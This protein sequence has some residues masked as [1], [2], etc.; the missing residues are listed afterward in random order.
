[1]ESKEMRGG[2]QFG[3]HTAGT[4]EATVTKTNRGRLSLSNW[5]QARHLCRVKISRIAAEGREYVVGFEYAEYAHRAGYVPGEMP[6]A[7]VDETA[8]TARRTGLAVRN[9]HVM[10]TSCSL[11]SETTRAER[12]RSIMF[13][14][15]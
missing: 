5:P 13:T 9:I 3:E 7:S 10:P 2:G 15:R 11:A 1:M 6:G 14:A 4:K 8:F 12:K